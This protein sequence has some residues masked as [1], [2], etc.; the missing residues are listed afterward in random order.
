MARYTLKYKTKSSFYEDE[1]DSLDEAL[2]EFLSS[3]A[4]GDKVQLTAEPPKDE[5][6][7]SFGEF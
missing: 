3:H 6:D 7:D 4:S 1:Y 5:K 2:A